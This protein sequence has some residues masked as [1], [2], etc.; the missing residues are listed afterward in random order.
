MILGI[1][2]TNGSGKGAVVEYLKTKGFRDFSARDFIVA[3]IERRDMPVDRTMMRKV[4]DGLREA[5]GPS[6]IIEQLVARA[7]QTQ[8]DAVVESIRE[9]A[10]AHFLHR[11]GG[12][13]LA[14]DAD[15]TL[16]Y[17]RTV[18]R[19]SH[20]DRVDFSTWVAQEEAEWHNEA[21]HQL[22]V[23]GVM[24]LADFTIENNGTLEELHWQID[25]M[26]Q[27]CTKHAG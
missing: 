10:G 25:R 20:T 17:E 16:R 8:G 1:T 11:Q 5:H 24:A 18:T 7:Q 13:L 21:A 27:Q 6:Y 26:L 23:L 22:N 9:I 14:V 12:T 4:A 19:G 3:E 2:G 15:R